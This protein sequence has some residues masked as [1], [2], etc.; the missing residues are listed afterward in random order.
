MHQKDIQ[1]QNS[2]RVLT[3][4]GM[5]WLAQ[6]N[7]RLW[8]SAEHPIIVVLELHYICTDGILSGL[9]VSAYF[10]NSCIEENMPIFLTHQVY[11]P[12]RE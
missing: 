1:K 9:E 7:S 6:H 4:N 10:L 11:V 2:N 3:H 8:V 5:Y 12:G